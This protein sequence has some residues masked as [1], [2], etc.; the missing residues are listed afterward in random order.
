LSTRGSLLVAVA[1]MAVGS[2]AVQAAEPVPAADADL[3][4]F[5][6]SLDTEDEEWREYLAERPIR[7]EAGKPTSPAA[8]KP[9]AKDVG[10]ESSGNKADDKVK[11]P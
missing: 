5:L 1:V 2:A 4:E 11:K 6:G 10:K 3:L 8:G 7:V 9:E